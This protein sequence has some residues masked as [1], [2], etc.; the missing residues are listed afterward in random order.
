MEAV[1]SPRA[2]CFE[3]ISVNALRFARV[4]LVRDELQLQRLQECGLMTVL[5][6]V[7]A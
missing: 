7:S 4:M 5:K 6:T 1:S 3:S 2:G